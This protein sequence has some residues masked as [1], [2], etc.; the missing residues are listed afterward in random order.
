MTKDSPAICPLYLRHTTKSI[1]CRGIIRGTEARLIFHTKKEAALQYGVFCC[2]RFTY[3]E[4]YRAIH[5]GDAR[6]EDTEIC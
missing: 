3:C 5:R 6:Q 1:E 4:I 2:A